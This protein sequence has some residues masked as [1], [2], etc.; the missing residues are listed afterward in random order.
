MLADRLADHAAKRA[1][2]KGA[3]GVVAGAA[4]HEAVKQ[5]T[6]R[7]RREVTRH[8]AKSSKP[9]TIKSAHG[10]TPHASSVTRDQ[11]KA[12]GTVAAG[13]RSTIARAASKQQR[14]GAMRGGSAGRSPFGGG[15]HAGG[16]G[17]HGGFGGGFHGGK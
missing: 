7:A 5:T 1:V 9:A 17:G 2:G 8:I 16:F 13:S 15:G 10:F 11:S 3:K 12:P 14:T 4:T 6:R